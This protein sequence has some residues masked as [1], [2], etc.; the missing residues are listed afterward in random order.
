MCGQGR[1]VEKEKMMKRKTTAF[2][3]ILAIVVSV[4]LA[5][6]TSAVADTTSYVSLG[7]DLTAD[8]RAE[9]L[10]LLDVSEDELDQD[11]L[12]IVTNED[13]HR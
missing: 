4:I 7:A 11:T 5:P 1:A 12:V 6:V 10:R 8:E 13:E 9:V 3:A 2:F